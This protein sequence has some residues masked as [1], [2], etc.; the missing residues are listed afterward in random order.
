[1]TLEGIHCD[2]ADVGIGTGS[3]KSDLSILSPTFYFSPWG[4]PESRVAVNGYAWIAYGV[5]DLLERN[6]FLWYISP[7]SFSICLFS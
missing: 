3:C 4:K 5:G 7:A 1:M 6:V 2:L